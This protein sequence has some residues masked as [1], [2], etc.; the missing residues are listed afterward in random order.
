MKI[1][2]DCLGFSSAIVFNETNCRQYCIGYLFNRIG[3]LIFEPSAPI[4]YPITES[5][6]TEQEVITEYNRQL[7]DKGITVNHEIAYAG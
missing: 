3:T 7:A 4:G 6:P 1:I 5:I 2:F